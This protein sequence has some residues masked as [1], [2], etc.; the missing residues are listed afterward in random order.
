MGLVCLPCP[1]EGAGVAMVGVSGW[2]VGFLPHQGQEQCSGAEQSI[3]LLYPGE[4]LMNTAQA[5][6]L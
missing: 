3:P 4:D 5:P 6:L 1:T 2:D